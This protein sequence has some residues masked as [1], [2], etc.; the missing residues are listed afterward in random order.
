MRPMTA[1]YRELRPLDKVGEVSEPIRENV[2]FCETG[3]RYIY[4]QSKCV[5]G[6]KRVDYL[7][8]VITGSGVATDETKIEAMKQWP[9]PSNLKQLRG[10]RGLTCYYRRFVKGYA[11]ISQPL[12]KLMKKDAF[13][14]SKESQSAF[15]ELKEAMVSAPVLK[16]P[17]FDEQFVVETDASGEG[18]GAILKEGEH[19]IAYFSK[20]LALRHHTLSTYENELLTVI[21]A[22]TSGEGS[23]NGVV[24][25][26]SRVDTSGQLLQMVLS[27]VSTDLLPKI[28]ESWSTDPTLNTMIQNLKVDLRLSLLTHFHY[29]SIGG[30]SV[31][32]ATTQRIQGFCYW[33]KLNKHV[34]E[35]VAM[36]AIFQRRK[37]DLSAYPGLLRP[38]L[39]P[40]LIWLEI[41]MDFVEGLSN[42]SGKTMIMVVVDRLSMYSH[43]MDLSHPLECSKV[44]TLLAAREAILQM[45]QFH[46]ARAQSRMKDVVDLH[47]YDRNIEVGQWV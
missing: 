5:F 14:W 32:A 30:H 26:L 46:L 36:C 21:Q 3:K 42:S 29:D 9:V 7:G 16:L 11:Y 38:L 28:V 31:V 35:F 39:I 1:I 2:E 44:D 22:S 33:R 4:K 13:V 20:T 8:H 37:D 6:T 17:N 40:T 25:T 12:T 34:K 10:F 19:P 41:S 15:L 18:I 47:M 23:E 43:F 45:L 27:T 24:D